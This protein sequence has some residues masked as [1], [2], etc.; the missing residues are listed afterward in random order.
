MLT[1]LGV[2][3]VVS[4]PKL[5]KS[6]KAEAKGRGAAMMLARNRSLSLAFAALSKVL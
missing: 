2:F 3:K 4:E 1:P 5:A 6:G